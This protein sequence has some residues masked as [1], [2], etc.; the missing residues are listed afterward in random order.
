[1]TEDTTE[2]DQEFVGY[3]P[4]AEYL[5]IK[6]NT[7]SGYCSRGNGPVPVRSVIQG[8]YVL[9]VFTK[10]CLDEWLASRPGQGHRSDIEEVVEDRPVKAS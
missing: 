4:A 10:T 5:G 3:D 9:P 1:M 7:L 2:Q 6:R 8:Q